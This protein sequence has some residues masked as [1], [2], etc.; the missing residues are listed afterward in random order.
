VV[1]TD[2]IISD[3]SSPKLAGRGGKKNRLTYLHPEKSRGVIS[4]D[5][6]G[7]AIVPPLSIQATTLRLS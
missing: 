1:A 4:G 3:R 2:S 6:G 7:Q 5:R